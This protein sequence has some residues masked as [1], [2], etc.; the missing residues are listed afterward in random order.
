[1]TL[2]LAATNRREIVVGAD[3]LVYEGSREIYR[4]Y[5][6]PKLRRVAEH[7]VVGFTGLGNVA[8]IVWDFVE[9][10]GNTFNPDIRIGVMECIRVMGEAYNEY[11]LNQDAKALLAGFSGNKPMI[12]TW[13]VAR[14]SPS[15]GNLPPWGA[16]GCGSDLALY[17][18]RNCEP[19]DRL[20]AQQL[21]AL[22]YFSIS[23]VAK[24]DL[25]VAKPIDIAVVRPEGIEIKEREFLSRTLEGPSERLAGLVAQNIRQL[26]P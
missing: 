14:P 16:I 6:T 5:Q 23:E 19:L 1:M 17:F 20:T 7:W 15:G 2:I 25:R 10:S 4:T 11:R 26:G 21:T 24:S 9:A 18:A 12:Y 13:E 3:T 22:V 8:K